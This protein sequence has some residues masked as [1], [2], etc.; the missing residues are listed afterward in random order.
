QTME[1][2]VKLIINGKSTADYSIE[3]KN[4]TFSNQNEND[5]LIAI[6]VAGSVTTMDQ[7][8]FGEPGTQKLYEYN[9]INANTLSLKV[10]NVD[11]IDLAP[12]LLTRVQ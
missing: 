10:I 1:I 5:I 8:M 12:L 2:P 4:I 3:G 6:D 7:S 11:G 9:C